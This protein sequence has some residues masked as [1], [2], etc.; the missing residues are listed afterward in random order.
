MTT[1]NLIDLALGVSMVLAFVLACVAV[2]MDRR[3]M[4]G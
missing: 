4:R 2:A 1:I 3:G